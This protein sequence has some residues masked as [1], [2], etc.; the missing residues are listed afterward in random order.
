[1][2]VEIRHRAGRGDD[3]QRRVRRMEQA[4]QRRCAVH[5]RPDAGRGQRRQVAGELDRIAEALLRIHEQAQSL[6]QDTVP[7]GAGEWNGPARKLAPPFVLDP[8]LLVLAV[9]QQGQ[10]EIPVRLGPVRQRLHGSAQ[11]LDR[12]RGAVFG[13]QCEPEVVQRLR[14][15]RGECERAPKNRDGFARFP[16]SRQG[17]AQVALDV[18]RVRQSSSGG[19]QQRNRCG[20]LAALIKQAAEKMLCCPV[21]GVIAQHAAVDRFRRG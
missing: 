5:D 15:R 7:Y 13:Q 6:P 20:D 18:G 12:L 2:R 9:A 16:R 3:Q 1:M 19:A 21:I 11:L 4:R 8:A 17:R 14:V 10:G